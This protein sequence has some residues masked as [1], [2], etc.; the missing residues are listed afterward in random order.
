MLDKDKSLSSYP[1][2]L[3]DIPEESFTLP[4]YMYTDPDIFELE[5][6]KIFYK[7]WQYVG[8]KSLF[9]SL[10]HHLDKGTRKITTNTASI[11]NIIIRNKTDAVLEIPLDSILSTKGSRRYERANAMKKGATTLREK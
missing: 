8:H 5:K 10:D 4:S 6:E 11:K 1:K 9:S 7:T 3:S 2:P